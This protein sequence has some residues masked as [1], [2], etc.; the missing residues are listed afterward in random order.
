[1]FTLSGVIAWVGKQ[2]QLSAKPVS[3]SNGRWLTTQAITKGHIKPRGLATLVPFH[4]HQCH[5][6]FAIK[7]CPTISQPPGDYRMM[8]GAPAWASGR[9][10]GVRPAPQ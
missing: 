8:G 10:A 7:T 4:L 6:V 3:L 1:M 9:T 5:S 2:A